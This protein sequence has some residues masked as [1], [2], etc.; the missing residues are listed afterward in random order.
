VGPEENDAAINQEN[1]EA[2]ARDL[3]CRLAGILTIEDL[4]DPAAALALESALDII[5]R[6]PEQLPADL[7]EQLG[8]IQDKAE[9][10]RAAAGVLGAIS[11]E[12][13]QRLAES[14]KSA[15]LLNPGGGR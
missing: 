12:T 13:M 14:M 1:L 3:V 9:R 15:G 4:M 8:S 6:K 11:P 10:F 5:E 7:V 2:V